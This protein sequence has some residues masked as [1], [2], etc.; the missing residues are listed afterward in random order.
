V[1]QNTIKVKKFISEILETVMGSVL[2]KVG[3]YEDYEYNSHPDSLSDSV[4]PRL[5]LKSATYNIQTGIST[6]SYH[7]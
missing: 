6:R 5:K 7:D 1:A 2:N 4:E 3:S